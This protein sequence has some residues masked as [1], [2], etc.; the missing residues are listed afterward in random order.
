MGKK[1]Y[2]IFRTV[3]PW[4]ART[5]IGWFYYN[6]VNF[7]VPNY[8]FYSEISVLWLLAIAQKKITFFKD[9]LYFSF[10]YMTQT[11][12]CF[13]GTKVIPNSTLSP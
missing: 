1:I 8:Q 10:T 13:D 4:I 7:L 6:M 12:L 3:G 2:N 5:Q 9:P 11:N